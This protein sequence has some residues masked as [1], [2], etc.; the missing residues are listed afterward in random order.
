MNENDFLKDIQRK[1]QA[2]ME[3]AFYGGSAR[4]FT[5]AAPVPTILTRQMMDDLIAKYPAPDK[6]SIHISDSDM[7]KGGIT[8]ITANGERQFWM[9]GCG[10][11]ELQPHIVTYN[12]VSIFG[13]GVPFYDHRKPPDDDQDNTEAQP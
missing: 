11:A 8:Q 1:I 3:R 12:A 2:D 6:I 4:T 7:F 13:Y 5:N 10:W 9:D